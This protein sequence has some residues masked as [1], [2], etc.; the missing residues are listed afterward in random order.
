MIV[1]QWAAVIPAYNAAP[2]IRFVLEKLKIHLPH[3]SILVVDD[4]S[5]DDTAETAKNCGVQVLRRNVNG[6]K[7]LALRDGFFHVAKWQSEWIICLDADGQHSPDAFPQFRQAAASGEFDLIIGTRRRS[8]KGM[9]LLRRFSNLTSSALLS[10]WTGR[11]IP[12][13]QCGY[14]ALRRSVIT[15]LKLQAEKYDIE[16]EMLLRACK[17]KL[18]IGWVDVPTIYQGEPSFLRKIPETIRFFQAL[19]RS[20][21]E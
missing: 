8:L 21:Y 12:D 19:A 13:A 16:T 7:G 20:L 17:L 3:E 9:P 2:S 15:N 5:T 14:R 10:L 1:N 18:R 6:G 4:G 11:K